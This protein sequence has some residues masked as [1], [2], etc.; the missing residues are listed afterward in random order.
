MLT[1]DGSL[2]WN[3]HQ[4]NYII[5]YVWRNL[6]LW[7]IHVK[8]WSSTQAKVGFTALV[9]S[10]VGNATRWWQDYRVED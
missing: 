5:N 1:V 2:L 4:C 9:K 7:P 8:F 10:Q 6:L 3:N